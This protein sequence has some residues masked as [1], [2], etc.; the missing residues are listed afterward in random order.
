[1]EGKVREDDGKGGQRMLFY[2]GVKIGTET[3]K[4]T[5]PTGSKRRQG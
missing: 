2:G 3:A 5:V 1:M 4:I